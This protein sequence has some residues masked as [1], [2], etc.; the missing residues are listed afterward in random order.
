MTAMEKEWSLNEL[1]VVVPIVASGFAFAF[2]VGYFLAFDIAWFPFFSLSEH[3]VFALR[4]LP[5]AIGASVGLVIA[6]RFSKIEEHWKW[7]QG[8]GYLFL[9]VWICVLASAG[10]IAGL[11]IHFGLASSFFLIAFGTFVHHRVHVS[12]KSSPANM[13][14][15]TTTLLVLCL[16][17]GFGSGSLLKINRIF[18]LPFARSMV[19]KMEDEQTSHVGQVIFVGSKGVLFYEY[20]IDKVQLFRWE[21]IKN[22]SECKNPGQHIGASEAYQCD[23][24]LGRI[25]RSETQLRVT[26]S[27]SPPTPLPHAAPLRY[28]PQSAGVVQW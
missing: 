5:I 24:S 21:K 25:E 2:V 17:T 28:S 8:K 13:L 23:E 7:L 19:V 14:Y 16:M 9:Y 12:H 6:L 11:S 4:A 20:G 27:S 1:A 26:A 10:F 15:W 22:V 3:V 18:D